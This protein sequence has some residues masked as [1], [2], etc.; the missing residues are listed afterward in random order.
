[1]DEEKL[2]LVTALITLVAATMGLIRE[3]RQQKGRPLNRKPARNGNGKGATGE[4]NLPT[5]PAS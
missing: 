2:N 5:S 1:M 4:G 3:A